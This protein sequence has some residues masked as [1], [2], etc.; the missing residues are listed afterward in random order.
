[1]IRRLVGVMLARS[2]L[3]TDTHPSEFPLVPVLVRIAAYSSNWIRQPEAWNPIE[4]LSAKETLSS[5]L[6][7]LFVRWPVPGFFKSAWLEK[8][9]LK[10]LERDWFCHLASGGSLRDVAGMP[11]SL[12]ARALHL[13]MQAP[14]GYSIRQALRWGQVKSLQG[15]DQLL[16]H[17][18]SSRMVRDL[19]NDAIWSRL[20][21]KVIRARRFDPKCF[22][23]IADAL[24]DP[25]GKGN[26]PRAQSLVSLPLPELIRNSRAFWRR[27]LE[28]GI[29]N[30]I[31]F[32][33]P[34]ID[35]PHIRAELLKLNSSAWLP[36][37][38]GP[39]FERDYSNSE[40]HQKL[41]AKIQ[42]L[43]DYQSLIA[44][45]MHMRHCVSSYWRKCR[46][47]K[48]AVFSLQ[49]HAD[50][51]GE[52][53]VDRLLTLEV[54]CA[55]RRVIQVRGPRN[56]WIHDRQIPAVREWADQNRLAL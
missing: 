36:F 29:E 31:H 42:E 11:P 33:K 4:G 43:T 47:G 28:L 9:D 19:S 53:T 49:I 39:T 17:V 24:S 46:A 32:R 52:V 25:L 56:R 23:L 34:D 21:E 3:M 20:L 40:R 48:S 38:N 54:D 41:V 12:S 27:L 18:L 55:R 2:R 35:S 26:F 30:G 7:H 14:E 16:S 44:E 50:C 45:G 37:I 5:L 13:A 51:Q 8:G 10:Y 15:S 22:G 6:D 1:M